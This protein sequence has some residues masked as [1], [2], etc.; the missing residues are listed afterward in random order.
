MDRRA[1]RA[2]LL[3]RGVLAVLAGHRLE[4]RARRGQIA[5]EIG[6][7]AQPLHVAADLHLVLADDGDVVLRV[8]AHDAG[9]AADA[10]VHVDRH[11]P[12]V[13][14]VAV[15]RE[16]SSSSWLGSFVALAFVGEIR[17]LLELVE[18]GVADNAARHRLIAFE[19]MRAAAIAAGETRSG[20][21]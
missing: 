21:R 11:A 1:D 5:F 2:N 17:V 6:V 9:I 18:R 15:G 14:V 13:L 20:D 8:A 7:D 16:Q 4:V 12:G 10:G 19:G 3:A